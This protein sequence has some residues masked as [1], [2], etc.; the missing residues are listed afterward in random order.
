MLLLLL[1]LLLVLGCRTPQV[2]LLQVHLRLQRRGQLGHHGTQRW[3]LLLL[4]LW[5]CGGQHQVLLLLLPGLWR[6]EQV[7]LLQVGACWGQ[8]LLLQLLL[9][10][11]RRH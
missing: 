4:Q 1:L 11:G 5:S 3:L 9:L 10:R 6:Q 7:L 8:H 2:G